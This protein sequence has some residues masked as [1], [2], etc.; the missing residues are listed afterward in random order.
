MLLSGARKMEACK[1]RWRELALDVGMW[2]KPSANMKGKERHPVPL[3]DAAVALLSS[4]RDGA[5]R[6][7]RSVA[8]DDFVFPGDGAS[9]HLGDVKRAWRRVTGNAGIGRHEESVEAGG[10]KCRW[11]I[12]DARPHDL[13][14]TFASLV[15]ANSHSLPVVGRLLG[16][17]KLTSTARYTHFVDATLRIA[18][19]GVGEAVLGKRGRTQGD[20]R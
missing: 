6:D 16:H 14:H 12:P 5:V 4:L 9:G 7:G 17:R 1:A 10:R 18:A 2:T 8:P 11:W 13:R 20:D 15:A 3:S 19:N